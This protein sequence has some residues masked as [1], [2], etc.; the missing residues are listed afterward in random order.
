MLI[1]LVYLWLRSWGI[2]DFGGQA[3]ALTVINFLIASEGLPNLLEV[4]KHRRDTP[5][6]PETSTGDPARSRPS[7]ST[8]APEVVPKEVW[9]SHQYPQFPEA[10]YQRSSN[11]RDRAGRGRDW[12]RERG[13]RQEGDIEPTWVRET[14]VVG[15]DFFDGR[16]KWKLWSRKIGPIFHDFLQYISNIPLYV[17]RESVIS[18]DHPS[19]SSTDAPTKAKPGGNILRP[20]AVPLLARREIKVLKWRNKESVGNAM[21]LDARTFDPKRDVMKQPPKW[22]FSDVVVQDPFILTHNHAELTS[23]ATWQFLLYKCF[24]TTRLLRRAHA[25]PSVFGMAVLPQKA[26]PAFVRL[27]EEANAPE[28]GDIEDAEMELREWSRKRRDGG[29]DGPEDKE[30]DVEED[31][32]EDGEQTLDRSGMRFAKERPPLSF[33]NG[34]GGNGKKFY[35]G[36]GFGLAGRGFHT[37]AA[38]GYQTKP[39]RIAETPIDLDEKRRRQTVNRVEVA[40]KNAY[41]YKYRVSRFGSTKYGVS[42]PNSDLD[43]IIID[44]DL[45]NG[46]P[47]QVKIDDLPK[48]YKTL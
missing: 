41:G 9:V 3:L 27:I 32:R 35:T 8:F 11:P 21:R 34:A 12:R 31:E 39:N 14:V 2:V 5:A 6:N 36:V 28:R 44:P 4:Q 42:S 7:T 46:F 25:L 24:T 15:A 18:I 13:L 1:S 48:V 40:I 19:P 33:L 26:S 37:S 16:V 30:E 43:L 10:F 20:P 47:P 17:Q 22:R 38:V 45:P 29:L 23:R